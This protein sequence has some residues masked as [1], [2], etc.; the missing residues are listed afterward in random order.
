MTTGSLEEDEGNSFFI[1]A[2][3]VSFFFGILGPFLCFLLF[4]KYLGLH[5]HDAEVA[6]DEESADSRLCKLY[7]DY[8]TS[9]PLSLT[10]YHF[11]LSLLLVACCTRYSVQNMNFALDLDYYLKTS[12]KEIEVSLISFHIL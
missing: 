5:D 9:F 4:K 11:C 12:I 1:I 8:V 3:Y 7:A 2:A 10:V 6:T